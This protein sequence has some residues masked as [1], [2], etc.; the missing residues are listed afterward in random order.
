M[1]QRAST[2]KAQLRPARQIPLARR[3]PVAPTVAEFFAG[4]GL[5]RLGLERAGFETVWA[6]DI[7]LHKATLYERVFG[8]D[9]LSVADVR[10]VSGKQV[11]AVTLATA[12][13]PCTDLS[14]A[15]DRAGLTGTESGLFWEFARVLAEMGDRRPPL[16]MLENVLGFATSRGG[17]DLSD[18]VARLNLLGY[19]CDI[20]TVD[21]RH[22]VPQSRPRLFVIGS[23]SADQGG[24]WSESEVRPGWVGAFVR[25]HPELRL[26]AHPLPRLPFGSPTLAD[27]VERLPPEDARWWPKERVARFI[28]SLSPL[29]HQR[30]EQL[31][32][33]RRRTWRTAYRRTR[34]G[35]AV[36]EIRADQIAGCLRTPRGGSSRQAVIEAGSGELR[37]RWM[38]PVE[39]ARLQGAGTYPI[40]DARDNKAVFGFGDAVCVPVIHWIAE[41]YLVRVLDAALP[42]AHV[43]AS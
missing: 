6:N 2:R 19:V 8:G 11:P 30:V 13:F 43:A 25:A 5:M 42:A 26:R 35:V 31:T 32:T 33:G 37:I 15:G 16:V 7:D 24:D 12:S 40:G 4:I 17:K 38:T 34:G 10:H 39:Y 29:Q 22:F 28:A 36:W 1:A 3:G 27:E 41:E 23:R 21:A 14:L 18:A 20:I 9:H